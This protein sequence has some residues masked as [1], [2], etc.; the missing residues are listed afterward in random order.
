MVHD[1][2]MVMISMYQRV[3]GYYVYNNDNL[4]AILAC[5]GVVNVSGRGGGRDDVAS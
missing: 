1:C 4:M 3:I 2:M 5:S